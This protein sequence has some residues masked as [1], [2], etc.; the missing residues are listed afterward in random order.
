MNLNTIQAA[1]ETQREFNLANHVS[2]SKKSENIN[3]D[4]NLALFVERYPWMLDRYPWIQNRYPHL[5]RQS[6]NGQYV[7]HL[8]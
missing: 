5:F 7:R 4:D 2:K 1:E 3:P 8:H 6:Q